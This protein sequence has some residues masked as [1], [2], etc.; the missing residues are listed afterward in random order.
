MSVTKMLPEVRL[1]GPA[2]ENEIYR[3]LL[4]GHAENAIFPA[5][6]EKVIFFV[7]RFTNPRM[8]PPDDFGPRGCFGVIGPVGALEGLVMLGIGSYWY[9]EQSHLE[10]YIVYVDP[11]FRRS[12]HAAALLEWAK[13]QQEKT[14][15]PLLS[16]IMSNHRTEAKCRLYARKMVKIGEYFLW[17]GRFE[18]DNLTGKPLVMGSSM[19]ATA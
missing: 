14:G 16:G 1:A 18:A 5:S 3:L 6:N 7:K 19:A 15:L 11:N 12:G 4:L 9:T 13:L 8:I 10:E 17:P 2:D